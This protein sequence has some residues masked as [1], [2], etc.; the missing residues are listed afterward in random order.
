M[1]QTP[2]ISASS[3]PHFPTRSATQAAGS[4]LKGCDAALAHKRKK[5]A[6][7]NKALVARSAYIE[8]RSSLPKKEKKWRGSNLKHQQHFLRLM[9]RPQLVI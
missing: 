4:W 8:A 1:E 6:A 5:L 9:L 7:S 2:I 3:H